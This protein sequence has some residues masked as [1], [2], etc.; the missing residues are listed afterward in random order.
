MREATR[1]AIHRWLLGVLGAGVLIASSRN[2]VRNRRPWA[3]RPRFLQ[4]MKR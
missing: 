4:P 3:T 2:L 1:L